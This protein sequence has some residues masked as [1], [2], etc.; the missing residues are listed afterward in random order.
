MVYI[1]RAFALWNHVMKRLWAFNVSMLQNTMLI[2]IALLAYLFL[3]EQL[4]L[5]MLAGVALVLLGVTVVQ[6][7]SPRSGEA[8]P[9]RQR[10]KVI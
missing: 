7:Y 5:L 9:A 6:V 1:D 4:T 10:R 8:Q 2:Q 3:N